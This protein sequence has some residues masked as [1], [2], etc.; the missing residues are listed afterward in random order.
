M[1]FLEWLHRIFV[2][3]HR[4]AY[5]PHLLRR[6]SLMFLLGVVL[7]A[8]SVM[9]VNILARQSGYDFLAAVI[10]SEIVSLTNAERDQSGIA[11]LKEN[12]R[13][14]SSAQAKANDM[15]AKGYF[16]HNSPDGTKPWAWIQE[17][18][19]NYKYAGENLAV[20]F[21]DSKDV[22]VA[23]MASPTHR[24]NVLK[25]TYTEIGIGIAQGTYKGEPATFVV[26]HFGR[27]AVASASVRTT[28][29]TP[30]PASAQVL[31]EETEPQIPAV[32]QEVALAVPAPAESVAAPE[33][34]FDDSLARQLGRML[35]EPRATT[36]WVLGGVVALLMLA[37]AFAFFH[38][39]QVQA[40]DLLLPGVVVAGVALTLL[41][42]NNR[43]LLQVPLDAQPAGVALYESGVV[44]DLEAASDEQ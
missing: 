30:A 41:V 28:S 10:Q 18:G 33:A 11:K 39:V 24:A 5:R 35:T 4:N 15:A 43:F 34:S 20:R 17:A 7:V 13:L 22:V 9:V 14:T 25:S 8:E 37:L 44:V 26:Q 12:A 23:W 40:H 1:S 31:G 42:V 32:E 19:Y 29:A 2:P 6:R 36:G 27:P 3:S 21:V 38:H 16:A